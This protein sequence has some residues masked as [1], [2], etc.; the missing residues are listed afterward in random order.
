MTADHKL[1]ELI[2]FAP[3]SAA[4]G[5][6]LL[7]VAPAVLLAHARSGLL[8]RTSFPGLAK[9]F[10]Y[11]QKLRTLF[12]TLCGTL[13]PLLL[14]ATLCFCLPLGLRFLFSLRLG[15]VRLTLLLS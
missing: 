15:S 1:R 6:L 9:L 5:L 14:L 2:N 4:L 8:R 12:L 13:R 3:E 10:L 11:L 7:G